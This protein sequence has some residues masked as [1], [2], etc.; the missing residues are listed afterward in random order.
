[1]NFVI[2]VAEADDARAWSL[3]QRHS[4]GVALPNRTYVIS[5]EA[6]DGL[7]RAGIGFHVLSNDA[8]TLTEQGVAAG[9]RI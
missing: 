5:K 4:P 6:I 7:R 1:M 8:N 9:E 2:Q 3:L